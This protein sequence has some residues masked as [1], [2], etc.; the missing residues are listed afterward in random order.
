M[1]YKSQIIKN[2]NFDFSFCLGRSRQCSSVSRGRRSQEQ[3]RAKA[4]TGTSHTTYKLSSYKLEITSNKP[5]QVLVTTYKLVI[6]SYQPGQVLFTTYKSVTTSQQL[7]V[8]SYKSAVTSQ[9]L[10]V[11]SYYNAFF[12]PIAVFVWVEIILI[13]RQEVHCIKR[14]LK[15]LIKLVFNCLA[16]Y[17][18]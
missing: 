11:S 7:Q 8:S 12:S 14:F 13:L 17:Y 4:R 10:Q 1:K 16:V 5:G 3:K 9:Q 15:G 6:T 2:E 18:I